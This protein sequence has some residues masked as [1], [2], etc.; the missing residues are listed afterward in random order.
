MSHPLVLELQQLTRQF[1]NAPRPAVSGL[2]LSLPKGDILAI[3]GPSGCGKTT[4]L[5]L[6]A[7]FERPEAGQIQ[8]AGQAVVTPNRWV[9]P[10]QRS[11]GMVFQDFALFPHL[12]LEQNVAFGLHKICKGDPL[13]LKQKVAEAIALVGLTGLE[14][15]YPHELSGGQQQR[16]ALARALAPRPALVLLDEPF[17]NL[18]VTVRLQLRSKVREI[19]KSAQASAVF[20]THDQEE[21]LSL[22]DW[23]AVMRTGI[24][25]QIDRP[26]VIYE[27][28]T[29]RFVAEFVTQANFIPAHR[30]GNGWLTEVGFFGLDG[31]ELNDTAELMVRQEDLEFEPSP[32]AL[33]V[34]H[35]RQFLGRGNRYCLLTP[36]GHELYA[37]TS[38]R[39]VIEPGTRVCLCMKAENLRLFSAEPLEPASTS[40]AL[41]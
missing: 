37:L 36:S 41:G 13:G 35:N 23:V 18:D 20:V 2:S 21:A 8:I 32:D 5:R 40:G 34:V 22:S 24:L 25:E 12:S 28:P 27:R 7:G 3:L 31:S 17:S 30:S 15:R 19:L 16:V 14:N 9:E 33:L 39:T 11:V 26:E 38:A 6:I 10:E 1:A 29:S 4:L